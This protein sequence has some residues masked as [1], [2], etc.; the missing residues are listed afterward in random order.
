[1]AR[2]SFVLAEKSSLSALSAEC[3]SVRSSC[4]LSRESTRHTS[5]SEMEQLD[6]KPLISNRLILE[7]PTEHTEYTERKAGTRPL[8]EPNSC[9]RSPANDANRRETV[10]RALPGGLCHNRL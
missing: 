7:L 4:P 9:R 6:L 5:P 1:M 8:D 3:G 10:R 2:S